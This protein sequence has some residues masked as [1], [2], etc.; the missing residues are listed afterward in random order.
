[1]TFIREMMDNQKRDTPPT[2]KISAEDLLKQGQELYGVNFEDPKAVFDLSA[3]LQGDQE[4][5][6]ALS[7]LFRDYEMAKTQAPDKSKT[8]KLPER[9]TIE[10]RAA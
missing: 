1:M 8:G 9:E 7:N 3:K 2:E 4:K 10:K 6:Y 5:L